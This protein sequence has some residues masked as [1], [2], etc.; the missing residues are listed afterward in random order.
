MKWFGYIALASSPL[1]FAAETLETVV[2]TG[3]RDAQ[4]SAGLIGDIGVVSKASLELVAHT[5]IS[6]ALARVPGTWISR[7]NGQEH[8]TAIRSPVLTGAGSCG[9]FQMA[10]D[11]IP[12]RATGFCN[13]NQLFEAN[14]EQADS[15]EVWRGPGSV[16][17]GSNALHG[18]VNVLSAAPKDKASISIEAGPN[19][20]YRSKLAAGQKGGEHSWQLGIN[21]ASDGGSK[22]SSGFD[23]QK[24]SFKLESQ[25][26]DWSSVSTLSA[27]NLNQETAGFVQ[28]KYA[29]RDSELR[30]SNPNPEAFRDASSLRVTS[31]WARQLSSGS[32]VTLTPYV[33]QSEM[34]FLQH[35]LP[36][37]AQEN[38]EHK[39]AGLQA[40]YDSSPF[41]D[42]TLWLGADVES[43]S[44]DLLEFQNNETD[45]SSAFLRGSIPSGKHYDYSVDSEMGALFANLEFRPL[46]NL[47]LDVGLRYEH[48]AYDYDNRMISGETKDNGELCVIF[49]SPRACRF[50]R[51]DDREDNFN[52]VSYQLGALWN[53]GRDTRMFVRLAEAY[54]APQATELYRLQKGQ[55]LANLD[56][57]SLSSFEL[58]VR[59]TKGQAT[60]ELSLFDMEK[61]DF[62]FRDSNG[63]NIN[64]GQTD[65]Q[66]VE[67]SL[68]YA[69]SETLSYSMASSWAK[70]TYANNPDLVGS[71]ISGNDIDTAPRHNHSVRLNW[72]PSARYSSE[73]EW[74]Y[75]GDYYLDPQN[76]HQYP[77]HSLLN[78]RV[79]GHFGEGAWQL[80]ARVSNLLDRRYAD[81]ADFAFGN[82]RYFTGQSRAVHLELRRNFSL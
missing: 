71:P 72:A 33:R 28:G 30:E 16:F 25:F 40:V 80:S 8:L 32:K 48:L 43:A 53:L 18:V 78:A 49:G 27:T 74:V 31:R 81:R 46:E 57:E 4:S 35:Y 59:G 70:H 42:A 38:N 67:L 15:I 5:H 64:G 79:S 20:Y 6:E 39:S 7:G 29:Y 9:E 60:Y 44:G 10:E 52:N 34:K 3:H 73:L 76:E 65:H 17:Y 12:L 36:G 2:V 58:G 62:I 77:G 51:P 45:S 41:G 63:S 23:Q 75:L 21:S 50:V 56:S 68:Q 14:T 66:G 26:G 47:L 55:E 24:L 1:T 11:S 69:I 13:V 37:Q 19:D 82:Y 61:D 54:R 22:D